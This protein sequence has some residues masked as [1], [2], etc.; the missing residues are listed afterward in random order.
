MVGEAT[1]G[2]GYG[3]TTFRLEDGSAIVISV[4]RYYTPEGRSLKESG[5]TPDV[6]AALDDSLIGM[7]GRMD[8]QT[9]PQLAGA[10][11]AVGS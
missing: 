4:I 9:D 11:E 2:K 10:I 5:V 1:T 7:I 8:A 6:E 3:Q